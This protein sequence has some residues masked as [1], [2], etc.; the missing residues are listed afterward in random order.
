MTL[1]SIELFAGAGGLGIGLHQ[2]GF[3][4]QAAIEYNKDACATL[5]DSKLL[6][7]KCRVYEEDIKNHDYG[8]Y[9]EIDLVSGGP[10]CQPFSVGGNHSAQNDERDMFP[11]AVRAIREL[12]PKAFI[13]ENVKGLLRKSF[14]TYFEYILLQLQHPQLSKND[15]ESWENHLSR[16]EKY[17]TG[18]CTG[19]TDYKVV[20]RLLNTAD[21]GV[22]QKRE[23][24]VIVGF[25]NDLNLHW[26]F[27]EPTHSEDR[28]LWEQLVNLKYW[29]R[30]RM[31]PPALSHTQQRKKAA[32]IKKYG[33]FSPPTRA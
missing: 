5:R 32:L 8:T 17:H 26:S 29:E 7:S 24:V 22:P 15:G 11:E 3:K 28:L 2:S 23:R 31:E 16:L 14:T 19:S 21:F 9:K 1:T 10:P 33:M 4:V 25:R 13:F 20:F 6:G 12:K 30:H 18:S 27:P